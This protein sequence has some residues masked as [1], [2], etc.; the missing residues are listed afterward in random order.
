MKHGDSIRVGIID[1]GITDNAFVCN[2]PQQPG[3]ISIHFGRM[4]SIQVPKRPILDLVIAYPRPKKMKTLMSTIATLGVN[5]I[6]LVPPFKIEK[7]YLG[8]CS[9]V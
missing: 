3:G 6:V 5:R 1:K 4:E 9:R 8:M 2:D 7:G